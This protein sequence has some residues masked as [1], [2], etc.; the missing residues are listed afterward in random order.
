MVDQQAASRLEQQ[1]L[2]ISI[3]LMAAR[4]VEQWEKST[5]SVGIL[6]PGAA[7]FDREQMGL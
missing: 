5:F 1:T 6:P 2:T 3:C 7:R 4:A